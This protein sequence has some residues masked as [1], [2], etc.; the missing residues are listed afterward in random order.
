M[1]VIAVCLYF[2]A[3]KMILDPLK[4]MVRNVNKLPKPFVLLR[5]CI[6]YYS[7]RCK[8]VLVFELVCQN[9]MKTMRN[10]LIFLPS[11]TF[12]KYPVLLERM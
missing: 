1:L 2:Q 5:H 3:L 10:L 4:D 11:E 12:V 6:Y 8:V 7:H 9:I